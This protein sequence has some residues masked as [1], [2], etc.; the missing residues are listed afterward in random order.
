MSERVH[1]WLEL[2]D[3]IGGVLVEFE[4]VLDEYSEEFGGGFL[5]EGC[6]VE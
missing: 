3:G 2:F 4:V 5:F 1:V 6:V